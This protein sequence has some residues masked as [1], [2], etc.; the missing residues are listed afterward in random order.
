MTI[1]RRF[2][3]MS[4]L[5]GIRVEALSL[6]NDERNRQDEKW[7]VQN[8]SP[9]KWVGIL[10][11]EFGEYCAAVNETVF[12]NGPEERKR[13]GYENMMRELTQIAAVAVAAMECLMHERE[14]EA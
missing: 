13:G 10:G 7:G 6:V 1:R 5:R 4:L 12:D 8:H 9:E 11:E 14:K 3:K 2:T